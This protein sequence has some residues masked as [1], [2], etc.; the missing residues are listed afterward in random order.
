VSSTVDEQDLWVVWGLGHPRHRRFL[1]A[2]S[3]APEA[4][5]IA[6]RQD[7]VWGDSIGP[8]HWVAVVEGPHDEIRRV[9]LGEA[10]AFGYAAFTGDPGPTS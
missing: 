7:P 1:E 3:D 4:A 9:V 6:R 8:L 10:A 2:Q 5:D